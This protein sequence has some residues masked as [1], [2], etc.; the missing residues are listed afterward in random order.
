M[1]CSLLNAGTLAAEG[2]F[3]ERETVKREAGFPTF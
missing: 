3:D 2:L 1:V